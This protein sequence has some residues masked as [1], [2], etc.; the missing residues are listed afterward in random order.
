MSSARVRRGILIGKKGE[1]I[2]RIG[3]EARHDLE[4]IF[5]TRVFLELDVRVKPGWR[6]DEGQI[7]RFGY[8]AD[9]E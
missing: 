2:K 7:R 1:M 3:T 5:D 9:S 8:A 6:E 4:R